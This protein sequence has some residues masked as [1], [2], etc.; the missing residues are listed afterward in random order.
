L[1]AKCVYLAH[2][3]CQL[4]LVLSRCDE[5]S[6]PHSVSIVASSFP[7]A[8][9]SIRLA[10]AR[11]YRKYVFEHP[12]RRLMLLEP[13]LLSRAC[14]DDALLLVLLCEAHVLIIVVPY[15]RVCNKYYLVF[16][17]NFFRTNEFTKPG[18]CGHGNVETPNVCHSLSKLNILSATAPAAA[19]VAPSSSSS[20]MLYCI[21]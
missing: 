6:I 20:A 1:P 9:A 12:Y 13:T 11:T 19:P 8:A 15:T 17:V 3:F 10:S 4:L 14:S 2:N 16:G 7:S 5:R 18:S 21:L